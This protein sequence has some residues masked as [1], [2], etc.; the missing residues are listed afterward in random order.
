M[1]SA[2]CPG[3]PR[4]PGGRVVVPGSDDGPPAC[5]N[6][7]CLP[8]S[9]SRA[10]RL[11]RSCRGS[12]RRDGTRTRDEP[13]EFRNNSAQ[14]ARKALATTGRVSAIL[15]RRNSSKV[16][17]YR[18][19][20]CTRA[21]DLK[22]HARDPRLETCSTYVLE[23]S[24]KPERAFVSVPSND[25]PAPSGACLQQFFERGTAPSGARVARIDACRF[26]VCGL[27]ASA[28]FNRK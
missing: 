1:R 24:K 22:Q 14:D 16:L 23:V 8:A 5:S 21:N 13:P 11:S 19:Y 3:G 2:D 12:R 26:R 7:L 18:K 6:D 10:Y 17:N 9:G 20:Y 25:S 4:S 27:A 28:V 15:K